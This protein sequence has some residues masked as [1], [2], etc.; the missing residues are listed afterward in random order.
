MSDKKLKYAVYCV[1]KNGIKR[2]KEIKAILTE[3][4][5][6]TIQKFAEDDFQVMENGLK[7]LVSESF[8]KYDV[9]IFIMA[10]G[11]VVRCIAPF[12]K[13]K[14]VD[15]AVIA[16]DDLGQNVISLLSGHLGGANE[17][18]K[19]IS[20]IVKGN[21][22]ITTASD[23]N[24]KIAVDTLAMKLNAELDS[25]ETA[26]SVTSLIVNDEPVSIIV[27]KNVYIDKNKENTAGAIVVTNRDKF[28]I[29]KIVPKNIVVGVGCRRDSTKK[30]ILNAI[31]SA[32]ESSN[33]NM[34]SIKSFASAWV[35]SDETGL[36]E[37]CKEL[38]KEI[39]FYDRDDIREIIDKL[40]IKESE[41]VKKQIGVGAV[42][43]PCAY[44]A[45]SQKGSF[46]AKKLKY[47]GITISLFEE[48]LTFS[49]M[50]TL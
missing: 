14:D 38:N 1:S 12:I 24:K 18:S 15:P 45:S 33:L 50:K 3:A 11:I 34:K 10:L 19:L 20:D 44:L 31:K 39:D 9:H 29:S 40:E 36:L 37:A 4:D 2:A 28:A 27:P 43:E 42:S 41:F 23:V 49:L 48:N 17:Q 30:D 16:L 21:S 6:Y 7:T 32:M 26:K 35:K 25:L 13:S 46:L 5:L 8:S 47:S 22:V